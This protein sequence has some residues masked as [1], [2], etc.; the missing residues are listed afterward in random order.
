MLRRLSWLLV[1]SAVIFTTLF[2]IAIWQYVSH[3]NVERI[4][5]AALADPLTG[6]AA[7]DFAASQH[8]I[9]EI[10]QLRGS[11]L[12]GTSLAQPQQDAPADNSYAELLR[13]EARRLDGVAADYE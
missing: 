1:A 5:A 11:V 12:D 3:S 4:S 2:A 13:R 8:V 10:R 9:D 7:A 6:E